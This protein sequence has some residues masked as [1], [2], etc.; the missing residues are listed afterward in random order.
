MYMYRCAFLERG[1]VVVVQ[2]PCYAGGNMRQ[3]CQGKD[4]EA[5]LRAAQRVAEAVR[6][7]HTH[8]MLH[9]HMYMYMYLYMVY[10]YV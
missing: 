7:L 4:A 3:W 6:F 5:R 1:D 8:G 9:R 2:S 10:A